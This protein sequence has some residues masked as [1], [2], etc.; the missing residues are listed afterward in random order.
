MT[1]LNGQPIDDPTPKPTAAPS[2]APSVAPAP[3]RPA[4]VD[5]SNF[6]LSIMALIF[7]FAI[8]F[9]GAILGAVAMRQSSRAGQPNTIAKVSFVLGLVFTIL[10][11][12]AVIAMVV[13]GVGLFSQLANI[14]GQFGNGTHEYNGVTY[15]CG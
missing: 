14:C 12:A 13:F 5:P 9:V 1:I 7:A 11:V 3:T 4:Q 2:V 10:I 8:P 15:T 6:L